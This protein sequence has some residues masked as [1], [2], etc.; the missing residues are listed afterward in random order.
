MR[1]CPEKQ[2]EPKKANDA[3]DGNASNH[4][5]ADQTTGEADNVDKTTALIENNLSIF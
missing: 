5:V 4:N 1:A 3:A 2:P